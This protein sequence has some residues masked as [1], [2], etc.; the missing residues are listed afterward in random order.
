MPERSGTSGTGRGLAWPLGHMRG[1]ISAEFWALEVS[2]NAIDLILERTVDQMLII[3]SVWTGSSAL[4]LLGVLWDA[5]ALLR[6]NAQHVELDA[7]SL[8]S[9]Q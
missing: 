9:H 8:K 6:R 1:L 4:V 7:R 3:A 5:K 2:L